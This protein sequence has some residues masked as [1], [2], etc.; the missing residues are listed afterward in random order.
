MAFILFLFSCSQ[1]APVMDMTAE[2]AD[3]LKM[4]TAYKKTLLFWTQEMGTDD[5][6][7]HEKTIESSIYFS[8]KIGVASSQAHSIYPSMPE[9]GSL[10]VSAVS[11]PVLDGLQTFLTSLKNGEITWNDAVFKDKAAAVVFL[12]ELSFYPAFTDWYIGEP[13]IDMEASSGVQSVYE[14]PVLFTDKNVKFMGWI[15]LDP[16]QVQKDVFSIRQITLGERIK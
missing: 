7:P 2:V 8:S 16:E 1:E 14:I 6:V 12:Y 3:T 11:K 10:D 15:Y 13:F 4:E 5:S 9:T